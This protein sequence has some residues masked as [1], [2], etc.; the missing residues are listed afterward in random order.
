MPKKEKTLVALQRGRELPYRRTVNYPR[1]AAAVLVFEPNVGYELDDFELNCCHDLIDNG[2]LVRV[3]REE[4][5]RLRYP[6]G[7]SLQ[8]SGEVIGQLERQIE[9]LTA[10]NAALKERLGVVAAAPELDERT[11]ADTPAKPDI[12]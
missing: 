2:L 8:S 12:E 1:K 6:K 10:E 3:E 7:E 11:D 9:Q 5:G 4:S